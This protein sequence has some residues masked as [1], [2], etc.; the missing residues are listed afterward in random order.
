MRTNFSPL[1]PH[2]HS[3]PPKV[4]EGYAFVKIPSLLSIVHLTREKVH[5]ESPPFVTGAPLAFGVHICGRI[6]SFMV[7]KHPFTETLL[8]QDTQTPL[9]NQCKLCERKK[10][11]TETKNF[12]AFIERLLKDAMVSSRFWERGTQEVSALYPSVS[13]PVLS[14]L[15]SACPLFRSLLLTCVNRWSIQRQRLHS[16]RTAPRLFICSHICRQ[17]WSVLPAPV[18]TAD[19]RCLLFFSP[20]SLISI[21]RSPSPFHWHEFPGPPVLQEVFLHLVHKAISNPKTNNKYN[22]LC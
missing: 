11:H 3:T 10:T 1:I 21:Y 6:V 18:W 15:F 4:L 22:A 19:N 9:S 20:F 2:R 14:H 7:S 17:M 5:G 13:L 12:S 8:V 16:G